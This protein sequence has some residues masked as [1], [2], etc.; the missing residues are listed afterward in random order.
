MLEA[1][2][3]SVYKHIQL[4]VYIYWGFPGDSELKNPPVNAGVWVQS[5]DQ[6]KPLEKEMASHSSILAWEILGR[7]ACQAI[8]HGVAKRWM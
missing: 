4:Y 6:E 1:E 8:V 7:G 3:Y 2:Q 5:L